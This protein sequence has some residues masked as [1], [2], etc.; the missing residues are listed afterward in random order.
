MNIGNRL[1][2]LMTAFLIVISPLQQTLIVSADED[3]GDID[4]SAETAWSD[5]LR[6]DGKRDSGGDRSWKESVITEGSED[7]EENE[8]II[9]IEETEETKA[10]EEK[11]LT[12]KP[13]ENGSIITA[14]SSDEYFKLVSEIPDCERIIVDTYED[15]SDL[16]V[17]YGVYFDG[18]YILGFED[19]ED[20]DRA[21]KKLSD[22][23]LEY[24]ADGTVSLCGDADE[25]LSDIRVNPDAAVRV[26]VIDTGSDLANENYT[27]LGDDAGDHNGHGTAMSS[28]LLNETDNAYIISIKAIGDNGQGNISDVYAAVQMAEDLGVDYILMAVSIRNTGKFDAFRSLIENTNAVVVQLLSMPIPE[29]ISHRIRKG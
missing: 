28:Y 8:E 2:A 15:M 21:V 26:A 3:H 27:I 4:L 29:R 12:D 22:M 1:I 13:E 5:V 9:G 20:Y 23:E 6:N 11:M 18:T 17:S 25:T 24:A 19:H 7:P 16:K 10:T 14:L